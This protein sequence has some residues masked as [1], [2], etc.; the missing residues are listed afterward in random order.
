[1]HIIP[2]SEFDLHT[3]DVKCTCEPEMVIDETGE[4][5]YFHIPLTS[6]FIGIEGL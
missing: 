4:I 1:M 2:P 3:Q 6:P 5:Y